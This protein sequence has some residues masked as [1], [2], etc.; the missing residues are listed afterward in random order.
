LNE[1]LKLNLGC[2]EHLLDGYV[3]VDKYGNPDILH[4]LEQ[5]PWPFNDNSIQKIELNHVLEHLGET[6]DVY[7][8]VMRELYR[9]CIANAE[10][11]INVPHPRSDDFISDPTHVRAVTPHGLELFSKTKNREWIAKGN[12]NSPLGL[13]LDVDFEI[14]TI[15]YTLESEWHSRLAKN[16]MTKEEVYRALHQ[17]NNVA[18]EIRVVLRVVK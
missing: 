18:K 15:D 6:T 16:M 4:D 13:Y 14:E 8:K 1:R 10:I 9:V 7:L 12:A 3:N 5:F 17:Y 11:V 2:G